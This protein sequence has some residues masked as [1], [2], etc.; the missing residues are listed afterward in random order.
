MTTQSRAR[1]SD[2][3][4]I[5]A[6]HGINVADTGVDEHTLA[7]VASL[8]G[9]SSSVERI[10]QRPGTARYHALVCAPITPGPGAQA[11]IAT[12]QRG[13]SAAEALALALARMFARQERVTPPLQHPLRPDLI[14][15]Q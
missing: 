9:W 2:V 7:T 8:H 10:G 11:T 1:V 14:S 13:A 4:Q 5:L 15:S 3:Y 12:R 6:R